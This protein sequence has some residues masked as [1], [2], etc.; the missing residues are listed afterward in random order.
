MFLLRLCARLEST[1]EEDGTNLF[2][3]EL[4]RLDY[5]C[6]SVG[7]YKCDVLACVRALCVCVPVLGDVKHLT[8][9]LSD[10]VS[11]VFVYLCICVFVHVGVSVYI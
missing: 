9:N 6:V 3:Q 1:L 10:T 11:C 7:W 5:R 2:D 4:K 8:W